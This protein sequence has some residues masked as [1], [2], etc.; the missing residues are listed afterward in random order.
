MGDDQ[1]SVQIGPLPKFLNDT[2]AFQLLNTE[3]LYILNFKPRT[4][5]ALRE[6]LRSIFDLSIESDLLEKRLQLLEEE[7][8]VQSL[9]L[10]DQA[11][12]KDPYMVTQS[13]LRGL[14]ESVETISTIVLTMQFGLDQK[15]CRLEY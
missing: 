15:L 1:L 7:G 5:S 8:C 6:S 11:S 12:E 3:L 13:G 4:L 10:T 2:I 14:K 9:P